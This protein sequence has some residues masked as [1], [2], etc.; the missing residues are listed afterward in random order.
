MIA[1]A[2]GTV[3]AFVEN[4]E[5]GNDIQFQLASEPGRETGPVVG[6]VSVLGHGA[7]VDDDDLAVHKAVAV[8]DHESGV[9]REFVRT[10]EATF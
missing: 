5:L 4:K 7:A 2:G 3:N 9:F 1:T 10:A 8:R 6:T